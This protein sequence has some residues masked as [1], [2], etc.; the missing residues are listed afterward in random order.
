[1]QCTFLYFTEDE[2]LEVHSS[3]VARIRE[4]TPS[5]QLLASAVHCLVTAVVIS[6][7][8]VM[9]GS[10]LHYQDYV[11]ICIILIPLRQE[12]QT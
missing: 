7:Y 11:N 12:C 5:R 3:S 1:M 10:H 4:V 9:S 6:S 2:V 8:F